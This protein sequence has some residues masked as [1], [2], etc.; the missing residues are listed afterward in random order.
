METFDLIEPDEKTMELLAS[1]EKVGFIRMTIKRAVRIEVVSK[2]LVP[3]SVKAAVIQKGPEEQKPY[4]REEQKPKK[5][6]EF[7]CPK[8]GQHQKKAKRGDLCWRCQKKANDINQVHAPRDTPPPAQEHESNPLSQRRKD[9][10]LN[11]ME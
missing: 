7:V 1:L 6:I 3:G 11:R 4:K 2:L 10:E 8:C 5:R 9:F